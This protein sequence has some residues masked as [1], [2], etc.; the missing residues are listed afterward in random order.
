MSTLLYT[1]LILSLA[2]A[3][4]TSEARSDTGWAEETLRS[5]TLEQKVGQLLFPTA[6]PSE[7]VESSD[8]WRVM[9]A[10]IARYHPGGIHVFRSQAT[11][12]AETIN[13]LQAESPQPL[14]ITADLEAGAAWIFEGTTRF[15]RGM[16]LAA[17]GER[18]WCAEAA[19][20]TAFEGRAIGIHVNFF[21]VLDVNINP[22][23]P[24]INVRAFGETPDDVAR[25]GVA[26]IE[27][28]QRSGMIATGKHFPGHGDTEDDSH[29]ELPVVL[30]DRTRLDAIELPPF[31]AAVRAGVGA[32][33]SAHI[34]WPKVSGDDALPATLDPDVLDAILRREMEFDGIVFTDALTMKGITD[35]FT[36]EEAAVQ[37]IQAGIDVLLFA[38]VERSH[39]ALVAAVRA[40]KLSEERI[41]RSAL[42]I[43]RAKERLGLQ[44]SCMV[45]VE[46]LPGRLRTTESLEIAR[47]IIE[48]SFTA[49]RDTEDRL[50]VRDAATRDFLHV[51][52][53]D[54]GQEWWQF[55]PGAEF[56][57]VLGERAHSVTTIAIDG[58][59]SNLAE[60][61][62]AS[63]TAQYTIITAYIGTSAF[64][65]V[66]GLT[67]RQLAS[68]E[69]LGHRGAILIGIGNPYGF[70]GVDDVGTVLLAYD[71][72]PHTDRIAVGALLGDFPLTGRLP[73]GIPDFAERGA[74]GKHRDSTRKPT[75]DRKE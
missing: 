6:T 9:Q 17:T 13:R 16:G 46:A 40:G 48:R 35:N 38:D 22:L 54:P 7:L 68:I 75:P 42:R 34:A 43:L 29:L 21:P 11:Q 52:I 55:E 19:R 47:R 27:S 28:L 49:V 10:R 72:E 61:L 60:A 4:V 56:A 12:A 23:N 3:V 33:M 37:A 63:D 59:G 39:P 67:E 24:I 62:V 66:S 15:P 44:D 70:A 2:L 71:P 18:R 65:G 8:E 50:P 20:V 73:V 36:P 53:A 74:G 14:L 5:M 31:R 25:Y 58:E 64:R 1:Y 26:Y 69:A 41:E 51:V 45:D 30:A 32:M 57:R